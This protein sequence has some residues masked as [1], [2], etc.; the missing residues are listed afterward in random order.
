M[1]GLFR[2]SVRTVPVFR[3][4]AEAARAAPPGDVTLLIASLNRKR[5]AAGPA[6]GNSP[7]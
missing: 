1:I 6:P 7:A 4:S 5:A 2:G 3:S